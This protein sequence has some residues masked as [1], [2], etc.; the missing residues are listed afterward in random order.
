VPEDVLAVSSSD[1]AEALVFLTLQS[2][3]GDSPRAN[4]NDN[5]MTPSESSTGIEWFEDWPKA[6][7]MVDSIYVAL[8]AEPS[9]PHQE[10]EWAPCRSKGPLRAHTPTTAFVSGDWQPPRC[11]SA[12]RK[13]CDPVSVGEKVCS[14]ERNPTKPPSQKSS[15]G[16]SWSM[17][18]TE[19][20]RLIASGEI[21][22]PSTPCDVEA[23][24]H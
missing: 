23:S 12:M 3:H 4:V 10:C 5:Q 19:M 9:P 24:F 6:N 11:K 15:A 18:S 17:M 1:I 2:G 22:V 13:P 16:G 8:I 20:K 7:D 21:R 14:R